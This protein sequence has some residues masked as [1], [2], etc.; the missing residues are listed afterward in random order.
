MYIGIMKV[1]DF[2]FQI[3]SQN[4]LKNIYLVTSS[5]DWLGIAKPKNVFRSTIN[6]VDMKF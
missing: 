1:W 3:L 5:H 2:L 6:Q 4:Q